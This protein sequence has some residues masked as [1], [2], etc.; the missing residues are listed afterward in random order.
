[1]SRFERFMMV[2]IC[3]FGGAAALLFGV[4]FL[5]GFSS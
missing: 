3:V 5:A 4:V 1:M 2:L